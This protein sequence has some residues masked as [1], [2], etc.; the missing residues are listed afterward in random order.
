ME[1]V[2]SILY[3]FF[4]CTAAKHWSAQA[5]HTLFSHCE[6]QALTF[7]PQSVSF[8][9]A[10]KIYLLLRHHQLLEG[11]EVRETAKSTKAELVWFTHRGREL[12]LQSLS[13]ALFEELTR[14]QL[15]DLRTQKRFEQGCDL[16][17]QVLSH[18]LVFFSVLKSCEKC[19]VVLLFKVK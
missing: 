14:Y 9:T 13:V 5:D 7:P 16:H 2:C 12:Q 3:I 1:K 19:L 15:C 4:L 11:T 10:E 6:T 8:G 18:Y 17:L